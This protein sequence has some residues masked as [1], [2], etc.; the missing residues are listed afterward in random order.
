LINLK[1]DFP[2]RTRADNF[3]SPSFGETGGF[4]R[5]V[6]AQ[7]P[8]RSQEKVHGLG[9]MSATRANGNLP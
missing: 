3:F 5:I 9:Y 7:R 6:I 2:M 1:Q 8:I 4:V